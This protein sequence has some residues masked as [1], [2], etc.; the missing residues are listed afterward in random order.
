M[1]RRLLIVTALL[2]IPTGLVLW[3]RK[4]QEPSYQGRNVRSWIKDL[5]S[6]VESIRTTASHALNEIGSDAIPILL[7]TLNRHD[8][9][10][11]TTLIRISE[12][13]QIARF[14]FTPASESQRQ[15]RKGFS[16]LGRKGKPAIPELVKILAHTNTAQL[17]AHIL[18]DF[19]NEAIPALL[20]AATNAND[21]V[22]GN[23]LS[24][25]GLRHTNAPGVI[26]AL[27]AGLNDISP[28]VR[29]LA[30]FSLAQIPQAADSAVHEL[31]AA[32]EDR[33]EGVRNTAANTLGSFGAQAEQ[34]VP[35]LLRMFQGA[36]ALA[37]EGL[38]TVVPDSQRR[39]AG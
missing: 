33:N 12:R 16:A 27:V 7:E 23:V 2:I 24:D 4:S 28:N 10:L 25:L 15:A 6:P 26:P 18:C 37:V 34:A 36:S 1:R 31:I 22:R 35:A 8:G 19:D 9:P 29:A 14:K 20:I 30:A 5:T 38:T 39:A 17:A 13:Q 11:K 21:V 3:W 32:L